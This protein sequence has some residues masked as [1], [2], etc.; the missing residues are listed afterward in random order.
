ML[1][2]DTASGPYLITSR[3]SEGNTHWH[4]VAARAVRTRTQMIGSEVRTMA[5]S[6]DGVGD[7]DAPAVFIL[8]MDGWILNERSQ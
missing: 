6:I 4:W 3:A 7:R 8:W 2:E 5:V 1:N